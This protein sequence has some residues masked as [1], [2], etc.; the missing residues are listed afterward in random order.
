M[1]IRR[2][3]NVPLFRQLSQLLAS[4]IEQ[5][6]YEPGDQLPSENELIR[7]FS[8]SRI[9][10]RNAM[11]DLIQKGRVYS[12]QG[13]GT[14]VSEPLITNVLPSMTSF[15]RDAN[16]RGY[17]PRSEVVDHSYL[18]SP[19]SISAKLK[20]SPG[21]EV[22]YLDRLLRVD[23]HPISVGLTY[24][25]VAMLAPRQDEFLEHLVSGEGLYDNF[26]RFGIKLAGGEQSISAA[27]ATA[28]L[29]RELEV[30]EGH[31]LIYS[32]RIGY[33]IH[34]VNVEFTIIYSR[35]DGTQWKVALGPPDEE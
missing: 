19:K 4:R 11:K 8:V 28:K 20:I 10:V 15:S 31:A 23:D 14:F 9:T 26:R 29:A 21:A 5:G 30:G 24:I 13:K 18:E 27:P 32:E 25:P 34:G 22:L 3:G 1:A 2:D 7:E 35:P 33:D 12:I 17:E 16:A 6:L